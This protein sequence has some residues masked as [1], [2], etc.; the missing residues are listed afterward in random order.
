MIPDGQNT[1]RRKE[2]QCFF[3]GKI[4]IGVWTAVP[5]DI[6]QMMKLKAAGNH[7]LSKSVRK[8]KFTRFH[9]CGNCI[10]ATNPPNL[11]HSDFIY[12]W[13]VGLFGESINSIIPTDEDKMKF[14]N[15]DNKL[16]PNPERRK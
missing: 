16:V 12:K 5:N 1:Y 7:V 3:C 4:Q 8:I 9:C 13:M 15:G 11:K 10:V 14:E 6:I 2:R